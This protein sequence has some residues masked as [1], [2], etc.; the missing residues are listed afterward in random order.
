MTINGK[1]QLSIRTPTGLQTPVI[2]ISQVGDSV[3]GTISSP[4]GTGPMDNPK[5][6]GATVTWTNNVTK[7]VPATLEFT[8]HIADDNSLSGT[9]KLGPFGNAAMTG[10][11]I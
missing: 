8:A 10:K 7:P 2:E 3:T 4:D 5:V 1:W 11:P 9:V 6:D